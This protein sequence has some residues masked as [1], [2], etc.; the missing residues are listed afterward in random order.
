MFTLRCKNFSQA[1]PERN[2]WLWL[3]VVVLSLPMGTEGEAQLMSVVGQSFTR[4]VGT[5]VG[6]TILALVRRAG[7]GHLHLMAPLRQWLVGF[8][9]HLLHGLLGST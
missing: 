6:A 2:T 9:V 8:I 1:C 5:V 7:V 3:A 4:R